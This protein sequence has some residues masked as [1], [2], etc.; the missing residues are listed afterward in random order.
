ML[1]RR[2][3]V[4]RKNLAGDP[5]RVFELLGEAPAIW[6]RRPGARGDDRRGGFDK[7]TVP[8]ASPQPL[9]QH[10]R[11]YGVA[12]LGL[13]DERSSDLGDLVWAARA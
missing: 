12:L 6:N 9:E 3:K 5:A 4:L 1:V 7:R 2:L 10:P 8:R 11:R 13:L